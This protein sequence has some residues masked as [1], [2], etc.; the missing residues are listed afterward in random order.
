MNDHLRN[1]ASESVLDDGSEVSMEDPASALDFGA[2]AEALVSRVSQA[3]R[4]E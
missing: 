2:L 3:S 4:L 1:H